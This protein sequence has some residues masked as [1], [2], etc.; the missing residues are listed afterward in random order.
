[1]QSG[2]RTL[3]AAQSITLAPLAVPNT[4]P[5]GRGFVNAGKQ[6]AVA[7]MAVNGSI[8]IDPSTITST[9][10][11]GKAESNYYAFSGKAGDLINIEAISSSQ[12]RFQKAL[13]GTINSALRVYDPTGK[14]L[15]YYNANAYNNDQFEPFEASLIDLRLP[16]DGTYYVQ[17]SSVD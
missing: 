1:Q 4:V 7:A 16:A 3:A 8:G 6:F 10:P 12:A 11:G 17:V 5:L 9:N 13:A 14:L 15:S 2:N